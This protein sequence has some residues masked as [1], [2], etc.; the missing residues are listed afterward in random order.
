[1]KTII[2]LILSLWSITLFGQNDT[3]V[4]N[5]LNLLSKSVEIINTKTDKINNNKNLTSYFFFTKDG[6]FDADDYGFIHF[7]FILYPAF[8]YKYTSDGEMIF[9]CIVIDAVNVVSNEK[10]VITINKNIN[11][12]LY[13]LTIRYE[14]YLLKYSCE[15]L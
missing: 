6:I 11:D 3:T 4:F 2:I 15:E 7:R 14:T 1:M 5:S 9:K 13:I 8:R 10:C 12:S